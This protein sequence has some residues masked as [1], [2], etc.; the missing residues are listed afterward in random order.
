MR[1]QAVHRRRTT[2]TTSSETREQLNH[3]GSVRASLFMADGGEDT[4]LGERVDIGDF[5][6]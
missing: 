4:E 6:M 2:I 5:A 3:R 1:V